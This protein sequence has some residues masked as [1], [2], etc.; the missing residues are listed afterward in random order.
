MESSLPT[1]S[2]KTTCT[3]V[4]HQ[5]NFR[6]CAECVRRCQELTQLRFAPRPQVLARHAQLRVGGHRP[7][8]PV[9]PP[10]DFF[11]RTAAL[12]LD[13]RRRSVRERVVR[14]RRVE[15]QLR[16]QRVRVLVLSTSGQSCE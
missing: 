15:A 13:E 6:L 7:H 9:L 8:V 4:T 11:E 14:R 3:R 10:E 16:G 1:F 5:I 2:G 12:Q